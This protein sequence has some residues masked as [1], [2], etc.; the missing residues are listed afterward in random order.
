MPETVPRSR[1]ARASRNPEDREWITRMSYYRI[2]ALACMQPHA[3]CEPHQ[4]LTKGKASLPEVAD[5]TA[6]K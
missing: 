3:E 1:A 5:R 4:T 2:S 6:T